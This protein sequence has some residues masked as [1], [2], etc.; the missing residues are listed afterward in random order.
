MLPLPIPADKSFEV[1]RGSILP[2]KATS[3]M[4]ANPLSSALTL[5]PA[6]SDFLLAAHH[7]GP[8]PIIS[9]LLM[10]ITSNWLSASSLVAFGLFSKQQLE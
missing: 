3:I 10:A 7:P 5:C 8:C 6:C 1:I 9:P 2:V 4:L